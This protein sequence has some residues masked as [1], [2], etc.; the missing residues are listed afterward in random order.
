MSHFAPLPESKAGWEHF[1]HDADVGVR[2]WGTSAAQ[3]FEQAAYALTAVIKWRSS[4]RS[5]SRSGV[6]R[7]TSNSYWS[8]G[9]T[10]SS[11]RW[12]SG[13]CC[14]GASRCGSMADGSKGG[15][16]ASRS[17]S[18][19]MRVPAI[20]Y[21]DENLIRDMDN[22]VFEQAVNVATLPGIVQASYAMPDAHW[23]Y[24]FRGASAAAGKITTHR[25]VVRGSERAHSPYGSTG[26]P[27]R[28]AQKRMSLVG[29][30]VRCGRKTEAAVKKL[31][32]RA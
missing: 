16:G 26:L 22:K 2:G 3:A 13:K 29:F 1:P 19:A 23:G 15:C 10:P 21:A 28:R 30:E 14:L 25:R 17:M 20:I 12:R 18:S 8:N 7:P 9:S 5:W 27:V 11:T 32:Q 31:Q 24:G 6:R 4:R